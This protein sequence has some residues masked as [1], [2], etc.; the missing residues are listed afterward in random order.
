MS[1][2][3]SN[4]SP[5]TTLSESP[6][7]SAVGDSSSSVG[8][9]ILTGCLVAALIVLTVQWWQLTTERPAPLPWEHGDSFEKLFRVDVNNGTW[10]EWMQLEGIGETM[11]HRIVADREAKGPFD[12][13]EDLQRVDGIGPSTLDR[14][15]SSL[16]IS[17]EPTERTEFNTLGTSASE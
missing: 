14:I 7:G 12:S 16:T 10:V 13:I 2:E 1:D 9:K 11:A 5:K 4:E 8:S 3:E 6:E 17:H 15:R